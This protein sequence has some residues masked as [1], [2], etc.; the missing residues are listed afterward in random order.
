MANGQR[1]E[2]PKPKWHETSGSIVARPEAS[3]EMLDED[4]VILLCA[5]AFAEGAERVK[6]WDA[7]VEWAVSCYGTRFDW[8]D[9]ATRAFNGAL[10]QAGL[11]L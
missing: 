8:I 1:K 5:G 2:A 10:T 6:V 7:C 3:Y 9:P 4:Q 11:P